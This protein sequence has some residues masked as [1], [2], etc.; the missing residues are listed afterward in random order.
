MLFHGVYWLT[1][2]GRTSPSEAIAPSSSS[3]ILTILHGEEPSTVS[4]EKRVLVTD[5]VNSNKRPVSPFHM[6][7]GALR[8]KLR[9]RE[10]T[11][12][13]ATLAKRS[14]PR[15]PEF[16]SPR[17]IMHPNVLTREDLGRSDG[18]GNMIL[19]DWDILTVWPNVLT[20]YF[21]FSSRKSPIQR[22]AY[23][24]MSIYLMRIFL[25]FKLKAVEKDTINE[26][27]LFK[28][29]FILHSTWCHEDFPA[30]TQQCDRQTQLLPSKYLE[31]DLILHKSFWRA[32]PYFQSLAVFVRSSSRHN[33]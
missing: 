6:P 26:D 16:S 18:R 22:V 15:V 11:R 9:G 7:K 12:Y 33:I 8:R 29:T 10:G 30:Y 21:L 25:V 19:K 1:A 3:V 13:L 5:I 32:I 28:R 23:Y 17:A 31:A 4:Y 2:R 20:S 24:R 27:F 14:E